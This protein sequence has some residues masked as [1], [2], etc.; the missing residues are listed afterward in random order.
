[1]AQIDDIVQRGSVTSAPL[2]R[3]FHVL[4]TW[5]ILPIVVLT[6]LVICAL[7]APNLAPHN[8]IKQNLRARNAPPAWYSQ[9]YEEHP[10]LTTTY[11]AG[12]DHVG[13][14][15]LSRVIHGAR[16]SMT[17]AAIALGTGTVVG[18]ALGL[19]AGYFRG[20]LDEFIMRLIDVFNSIPFLLIALVV[21]AVVGPSFSLVLGLLALLA[22]NAFVRNVRAEVLS[23]RERD[24]V[25]LA[26]VC[27]ASN[28]RIMLKHILPG[29]VNTVVVIATLRVGQLILAEA[30][31]SFLGV[32][33]P[34]P[35]PA[36]GSMVADGRHYLSDAWWIAFFPGLAI[37]LVVMSLNFLGDWLRDRLDPRLRQL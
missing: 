4:R 37:F 21:V 1:M 13:R 25:A 22:W 8:P 6:G 17:V 9:W 5:P 14:D 29:V 32:G 24:Y 15:V 16:I 26:R 11:L 35:T 27:G 30:S 10:K 36:W 33:I 23:L 28:M 7:F 18:S 3:A 31:L 20:A 2:S 12:A 34:K 19:V